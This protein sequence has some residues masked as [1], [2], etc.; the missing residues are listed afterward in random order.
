MND[1]N[2]ATQ[3]SQKQIDGMVTTGTSTTGSAKLLVLAS[4][5]TVPPGGWC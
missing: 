2:E 3:K 4:A 1:L 5:I